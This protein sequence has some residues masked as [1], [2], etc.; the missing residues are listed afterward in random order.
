[1]VSATTATFAAGMNT[2]MKTSATPPSAKAIGIPENRS[3]EGRAAVE[4]AD[5]QRSPITRDSLRVAPRVPRTA[6]RAAAGILDDL[7]E[8]QAKERH[9][10]RHEDEGNPQLRRPRRSC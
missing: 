6:G 4:E 7:H 8:L 3:E 5:L 2:N 10:E 1:M 9:A